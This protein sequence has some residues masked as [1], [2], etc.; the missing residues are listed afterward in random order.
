LFRIGISSITKEGE[1][2]DAVRSTRKRS[3][4]FHSAIRIVG[5]AA[6]M[7]DGK[8]RLIR[9]RRASDEL[10]VPARLASPITGNGVAFAIATTLSEQSAALILTIRLAENPCDLITSKAGDGGKITVR[11]IHSTTTIART[12]CTFAI[13]KR[14]ARPA[15]RSS[16]DD[17]V[18]ED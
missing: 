12:S 16:A 6:T 8:G 3:S 4:D 17:Y 5:T 11:I 15:F 1:G 2:F 9:S 13:V 14:I 7:T 18:G 10:I